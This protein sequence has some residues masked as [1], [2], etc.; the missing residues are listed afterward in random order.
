MRRGYLNAHDG[1]RLIIFMLQMFCSMKFHASRLAVTWMFL[2][3]VVACRDI[4]CLIVTKIFTHVRVIIP[5]VPATC[6]PLASF[7]EVVHVR[8]AKTVS[9]W[10]KMRC[11]W[12]EVRKGSRKSVNMRLMISLLTVSTSISTILKIEIVMRWEW[13][14]STSENTQTKQSATYS[15][16]TV[17]SISAHSATIVRIVISTILQVEK[18]MKK[19]EHNFVKSCQCKKKQRTLSQ[20]LT[21]P[22]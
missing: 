20:K 12:V 10:Q 6:T 2:S 19:C 4:P 8:V 14:T 15:T 5:R 22:P 13:Y 16:V 3:F 9:S 7:R 1:Q 11:F 21:P 18:K 17:A